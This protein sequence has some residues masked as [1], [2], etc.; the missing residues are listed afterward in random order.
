MKEQWSALVGEMTIEEKIALLTGED[1]FA[2]RG[3]PRLG[4]PSF[5]MSDGPHGVRAQSEGAADHLGLNASAAATCFPSG[6][7]TASSWNPELARSIGKAVGEEARYYGIRVMLGPA[8]NIK[9][10][11][12]CGR[13]FEYYSEDP[14]LAGQLAASF[15]QGMQSNGVAACLKHFACNNQE[16]RRMV[17]NSVV[18]ERTLREIYLPAF[19]EAV[20]EGDPWSVMCA[21]NRING[22]FCSEHDWLLNRVLRQEWGFD[23]VVISDWG[24]VSNRAKALK[25]GLDLEMPGTSGYSDAYLRQG[26][27]DGTITEADLDTSVIRLLTLL[28][29]TAD[30]TP[31]DTIDLEG[32]HALAQQAAEE[33]LVLLKNEEGILP[34][35]KDSKIAVLG[36]LAQRPRY[37][38]GGSSHVASW[39][40]DNTLEEL[41][42]RCKEQGELLYADGYSM[43]NGEEIS[44]DYLAPAVQMAAAAETAVLFLGLT[45][46]YETEGADRKDMKL[47]SAH[48]E[49]LRRVVA[50]N[51]N[52]VVVLT[53]GAP[54]E[55]PWLQQVKGVLATYT[56]GDGLGSAVASVLFGEVNPSGKLAET[57][58]VKLE[59]NPSYL[60]FRES[61]TDI[62]YS[63][64]IF[65]G[66]RWY[67]K[68]ALPVA[69][70]FGHGLSYTTFAYSDL[71][72]SHTTL[73]QGETLVVT[74]KVTN[75]GIRAGKECVQLYVGDVETS[76]PRPVK[77][78]KGFRKV[79][80]EPGETKVLTFS[81][82]K[83][84]FAFYDTQ[85]GDWAVEP[86]SFLI[87]V[88]ASS[89]D[90]R[91]T[92]TVEV[93]AEPW[94]PLRSVTQE[95]TYGELVD[96]PRTFPLL[97]GYLSQSPMY[98]PAEMPDAPDFLRNLPLWTLNHMAGRPV[99][100]QQLTQW[101]E[102]LNQAIR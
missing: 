32:H 29:R 35:K 87:S 77:E 7:A 49:L 37:Q 95:T 30:A 100:P 78:L 89:Q 27:E 42:D 16:D 74:M 34:L 85:L 15:V 54:V 75:T 24:A 48:E 94:R 10:S 28:E 33:C 96:D 70:P 45:E 23:G 56:A 82:D 97:C 1:F 12:L 76:L 80:L 69:F 6:A 31:V 60:T 101:V 93:E 3:I 2:S 61:K 36:Q 79:L 47:P 64:G 18:D 14:Y 38:G 44:E 71:T 98:R 66:Y 57:M 53:A 4:I 40:V 13:N 84:A 50:V 9:R 17:S 72:L 83:R 81:L 102:E 26:L 19:E 41:W 90:I 67:E 91:L 21:Y 68:R 11:P 52:V 43:E 25:G 39:K 92:A 51:P 58:P 62:R 59:H 99:S 65:V 63:E 73:P 46:Q 5:H 86:G 55:M 8:F 22:T 20:K 88:G